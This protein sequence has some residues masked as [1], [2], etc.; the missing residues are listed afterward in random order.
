MSQT[1][2]VIAG[3]H[4]PLPSGSRRVRD[5]DPNAHVEV[6]IMLKAPPLPTPDKMP[7]RAMS[8]EAFAREY[9]ADPQNIAKVEK[10]LRSYGLHI[11]GVGPTGRSLRVS[12]TASA[13]ESAFHAGLGIYENAA[14]GQFRAREGALSAPADIAG[15]VDAVIGLDQR[16]VAQRKTT[17]VAAAIGVSPLTPAE[18]EEHYNFPAG[19]CA[20]QKIAIAEFGSPLQSGDFL[21]PAYFPDD[22]TAFCQQQGR[23]VPDVQTVAVNLA[24][25][26]AAQFQALSGPSADDVLEETGEVMMDVQIV[27]TLCSAASISVYYASFDQKGWVDL[28]ER[29]SG[30][31]PVALS[32]SYGL[33]ED[34]PDW[35][36]A[37]LQAINQALQAAAMM[38]ITVCVSSGDDGSGCD[39][40]DSRGHVEFP[41][42]SP[43]VLSVG[44][45]MISDEEVVWWQSPGRRTGNGNSGATGGGVSTIFP[46]PSWQTIDIASINSTSIKGRIVP[47]VAALA[48][49]PL[50][51]LILLGQSAPNGG[52]SASA[53]VWTSLV[54][55]I[56]AAL[57]AAKKQRFLPPLLYQNNVGTQGFTDITS[58][59]NASHPKPGK[60]YAAGRGFDAVSGWG[61][62][63]GEKLLSVL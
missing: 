55:R 31:Q 46:R 11:E 2:D 14:Q 49:P 17:K 59:N 39:M 28:V 22:L 21:P 43:F 63:N 1:Y 8:P 48:G 41:G 60:G 9:G 10:S 30:D 33:A 44:G 6:T 12:G 62:P 36:P 47:D 57:P 38:G 56:N 54:G 16:R 42:C 29:V 32:I 61:V 18:I 20:G 50:Y 7:A 34:S 5:V 51:A 45:T 13:M 40:S 27:A 52:T 3:T 35:E 4:R 24:P 53:P 26:T 19:D 25:L 37:A 15:L 23:P 58:G